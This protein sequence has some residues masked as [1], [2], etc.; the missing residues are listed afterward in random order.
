MLPFVLYLL[1]PIK[2]VSGDVPHLFLLLIWIYSTYYFV[3]SLTYLVLNPITI[4]LGENVYGLKFAS[5]I[6]NMIIKSS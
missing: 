6:G 1:A 2:K 5:L 3:H 4:Y